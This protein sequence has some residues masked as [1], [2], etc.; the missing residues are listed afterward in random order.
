LRRSLGFA[1]KWQTERN[2]N[3]IGEVKRVI[4]NMRR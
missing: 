1:A 3:E 4:V 2:V